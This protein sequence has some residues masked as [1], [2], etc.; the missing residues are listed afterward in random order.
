MKNINEYNL[1]KTMNTGQRVKYIRDLLGLTRSQMSEKSK[2][3]INKNTLASIENNRINLTREAALRLFKF[4]TDNEIILT[5]EWLLTGVGISPYFGG[6]E[7]DS[8]LN[9]VQE[10]NYFKEVNKQALILTVMDDAMSPI[11]MVG[12]IVGGVPSRLSDTETLSILLLNDGVSVIRFVK[13]SGTYGKYHTFA[14]NKLAFDVYD[15]SQVITS[16]K[17]VWIRRPP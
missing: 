3:I 16:F 12:D 5:L 4:A 7:V 8:A 9:A 14:F 15:D 10:A 2:G 11:L 13:Y 6:Q 1:K 17:V